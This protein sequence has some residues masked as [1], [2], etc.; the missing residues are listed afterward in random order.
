MA[1]VKETLKSSLRDG[2]SRLWKAQSNKATEDGAESQDPEV[3]IDN[4]ASDMADVIA[5]AIDSYIRSGDIVVG[6]TNVSVICG[7][8]GSP[9]AVSPIKPAKMN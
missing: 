9:G 2:F 5:N 8:P 4:M 6:P 7:S 1:L 3:I